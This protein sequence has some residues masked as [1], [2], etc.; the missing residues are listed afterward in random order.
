MQCRRYHGPLISI[1]GPLECSGLFRG[2]SQVSSFDASLKT[3]TVMRS[4]RR[5][6]DSLFLRPLNKVS[7]PRGTGA[8]DDP[9]LKVTTHQDPNEGSLRDMSVR[10]A[11]YHGEYAMS[12]FLMAFFEWGIFLQALSIGEGCSPSGLGLFTSLF[13]LGRWQ[14]PRENG[15]RFELYTTTDLSDPLGAPMVH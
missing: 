15:L 6:C 1:N 9:S 2:F 14:V 11:L 7:I 5:W 12:S 4:Y 8:P 13:K 3:V 10:I